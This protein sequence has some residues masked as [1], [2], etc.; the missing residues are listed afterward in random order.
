MLKIRISIYIYIVSH[1]FQPL[2]LLR[3]FRPV[4]FQI[5]YIILLFHKKFL[6]NRT[7][8]RT[9]TIIFIQILKI[10]HLYLWTLQKLIIISNLRESIIKL[11]RFLAYFIVKLILNFPNLLLF[12]S[13]I[14]RPLGL[15]G[16][17][18]TWLFS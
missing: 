2:L 9:L 17:K 16:A 12:L 7:L 10:N 6:F 4:Y 14:F 1:F 5:D 8:N 11:L 3:L 13:K 18:F 15:F